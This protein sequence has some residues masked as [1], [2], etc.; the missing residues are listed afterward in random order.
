MWSFGD[1]V[2]GARKWTGSVI[3]VP[4]MGYDGESYSQGY[5]EDGDVPSL[6]L[7]R[8]MTGELVPVYGSV[9]AFVD[10]EVF[11]LDSLSDE[12]SV[13][14]SAV[15]LNEAYPN[16]FN[17]VT[18]I[19][20]S[21]PE[22]MAVELTVLDIQGRL[23]QRIA[24]GMYEMGTHHVTLNGEGLSSGLYFVRLDAGGSSAYTKVLLLK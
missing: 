9:P 2:V 10:N 8:H 17:P 22:M 5:L 14:P 15:A 6:M 16:P 24:Q 19:E 13:I 12:G 7:Y 3:D 20:F 1:V 23:V 21:V 18:N 4:A 11:I